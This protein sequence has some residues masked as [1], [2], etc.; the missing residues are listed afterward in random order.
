MLW[1]SLS[2]GQGQTGSAETCWLSRTWEDT[3][4]C[5]TLFLVATSQ[6]NNVALTGGRAGGIGL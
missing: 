5:A 4:V 2:A 6:A 1:N 3:W